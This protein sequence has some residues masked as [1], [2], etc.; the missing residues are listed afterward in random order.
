MKFNLCKT[1][2]DSFYSKVEAGPLRMTNLL[3]TDKCVKSKANGECKNHM[4][5]FPHQQE[6]EILPP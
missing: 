3:F 2:C 1:K 5:C 6:T 4:Q